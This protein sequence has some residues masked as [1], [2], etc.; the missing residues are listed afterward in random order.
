MAGLLSI[1]FIFQYF[2]LALW[3]ILIIFLIL[4]DR[5]ARSIEGRLYRRIYIVIIGIF[6]CI[7]LFY[8][9]IQISVY[10]L[11]IS[12]TPRNPVFL[13]YSNTNTEQK[14]TQVMLPNGNAT[15]FSIINDCNND[16]PNTKLDKIFQWEMD[17]WHNPDW[18]PG[19][20]YRSAEFPNYWYYKGNVSKVLPAPEYEITLFRQKN[21]DGILYSR[22]PY[23][24]AHNK[25]GACQQLSTLFSF[26]ANKAGI[27]SR[28][29]QSV[30][31]Q[32]AEV[33]IDN[34]TM[35]YDP[36]CAGFHKYYNSSTKDMTFRYKWFNTSE[37]FEENCE[38]WAFLNTYHEYPYGWAT[39][40]YD[41]AF[42]TH[43]FSS[44]FK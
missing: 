25:V 4:G 12:I 15:I 18:E 31:H 10:P 36:W 13:L 44:I 6:F 30:N 34:K 26:M 7:I 28:L 40:D 27:K 37:Y 24:L 43:K 21:P 39:I 1:D 11:S 32:W 41:I 22:D 8:F 5:S 42:I 2:I 16:N 29:V 19:T 38:P 14:Y 3:V 35:Y 9:L 33:E 23:W 17:D 20:F